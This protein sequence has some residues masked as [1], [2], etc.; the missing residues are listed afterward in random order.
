MIFS[1]PGACHSAG[2]RVSSGRPHVSGIA[3]SKHARPHRHEGA[4]HRRKRYELPAP[5]REVIG[6]DPLAVEERAGLRHLPLAARVDLREH[7]P[8]LALSDRGRSLAAIDPMTIPACETR[9]HVS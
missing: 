5:G 8:P 4:A 9:N 2:P 6:Y 7:L 1:A 3:R